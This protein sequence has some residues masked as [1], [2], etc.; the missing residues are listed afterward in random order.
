M[1]N[2]NLKEA[3]AAKNDEFYTQYH[4]IEAEMNAYLEYNPNVFRGKTILLPC[5]DP[6]WSNFTRFFVAKF[7]ELGIKKLISTS[8]AQESKN[9]KSD[10]QPTLFE[11]EDPRF[12]AEKTAICGKIFTLTGD[13]NKNG[14]IDIDDLE[15]DYLEGTGDFRSPEVTALRNEADIIITNPPFSLFREFL[16]WVIEGK[17]LFAVIE[18][19]NIVTYKEIFP[20][21]KEDKMWLG[22]TIHSGDVKFKIPSHYPIM[23]ARSEVDPA[24]NKFVRV[25][26]VRWFTNIKHGQQQEELPLRTMEENMRSNKRIRGKECY[27]PYD[28]YN[29]VEIPST[30][31]IPS[32]YKGRMGVPITFLDKYNPHQ[33]EILTCAGQTG[34]EKLTIKGREVYKRIIIQ[35]R[36]Q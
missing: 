6:E 26:N 2:R 10:W 36:P 8:F 18:T 14:R 16:K 33:F 17:K 19:M 24:G 4:D 13:T 29:A 20:L 32:D 22:A 30:S 7:E 1:A 23:A 11:S 27:T 31:A 35:Y 9:Y 5:D 3:K 34:V 25:T 15:W 21:I 28:N 12:S